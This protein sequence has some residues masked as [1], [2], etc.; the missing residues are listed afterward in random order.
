MKLEHQTNCI[1][2]CQGIIYIALTFELILNEKKTQFTIRVFFFFL[3]GQGRGKKE[4]I[5]G[6][7]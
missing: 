3:S 7:Q 6:G 4:V 5:Q 2:Y 1:Y